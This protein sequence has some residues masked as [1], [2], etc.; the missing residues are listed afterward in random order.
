MGCLVFLMLLVLIC[1]AAPLYAT[2]VSGQ[3]PFAS[4][5]DGMISLGGNDVAVMQPDPSGFGVTPIGPTWH[6]QYFLGSDSQGRDVMERLL[7]GGRSSLLIATLGTLL[8][9]TVAGIIGL[10]AGFAGGIVDAVLARVLDV[11]W[12][13]PIYFLAVSLSVVLLNQSTQIGPITISAGSLALPILIMGVLYV[14]YVARPVRGQVL[15]LARTDFVLAARALGVPPWRILIRDILPNVTTTLIVFVPIMMALI[16][17]TESAL[18][19]LSLGVQAPNASWGTIIEDGQTMLYTRPLVAIA[20]GVCIVLCVLAL[21]VLGDGVR[22]A[23]DPR[24]KLR[25]R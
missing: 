7:Y 24:A 20:P 18:S 17:L 5:I 19:F 14:P 4:N 3:D 23:L 1:A 15:S 22:D 8:C 11:L 6:G 13:F 12:A 21:N 9:L 2:Y 25:V 10:V 16:M